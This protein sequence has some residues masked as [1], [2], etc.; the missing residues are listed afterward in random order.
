MQWVQDPRHSNV[1]NMNTI[2]AWC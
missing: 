2:K 1:Y